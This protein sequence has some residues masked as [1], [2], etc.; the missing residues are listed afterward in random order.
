[1]S[2]PSK[3][4][5]AEYPSHRDPGILIAAIS[6]HSFFRIALNI[7]PGSLILHAAD[8]APH[9]QGQQHLHYP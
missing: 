6:E 9:L 1:M 5:L 7:G 4:L 2:Y 3:R 8:S